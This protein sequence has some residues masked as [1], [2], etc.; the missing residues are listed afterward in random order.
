MKMSK[1]KKTNEG[2]GRGLLELCD[3]ALECERKIKLL[4]DEQS[5]LEKEIK[6][7]AKGDK[8]SRVPTDGGGYSLQYGCSDGSFVKVTKYGDTLRAALASDSDELS[9]ARELAGGAFDNLFKTVVAYSLV[10]DF[11][12]EAERLAPD[13][14]G[15][16]IDTVSNVGKTTVTYQV[17]KKPEAV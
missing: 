13:N 16:L 11:R 1:A 8:E 12:K 7:I 3:A 4:K 9:V 15:R 14:A 6:I 17:A 10:P 5:K 2:G